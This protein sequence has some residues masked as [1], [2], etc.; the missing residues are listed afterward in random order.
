MTQSLRLASFLI[1]LVYEPRSL[2]YPDLSWARVARSIQ[3]K[4]F[5]VSLIG[6]DNHPTLDF[7]LTAGS[8]DDCVSMNC[9]ECYFP[10]VYDHN[11]FY[12]V[13]MSGESM[14]F[15]CYRGLLW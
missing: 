7:C 12:S 4:S 15:V 10:I 2:Q 3:V 6:E 11:R 14:S 13:S 8:L 9:L 1:I 5:S